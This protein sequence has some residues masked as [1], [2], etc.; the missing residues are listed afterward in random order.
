M[1]NRKS[2]FHVHI[3]AVP[4]IAFIVA[5]ATAAGYA[6]WSKSNQY[7]SDVY[8]PYELSGGRQGLVDTKD[9][10]IYTNTEIG[11]GVKYPAEFTA[12]YDPGEKTLLLAPGKSKNGLQLAIKDNPQSLSLNDWWKQS[13]GYNASFIVERISGNGAGIK[14]Y[15]SDQ[16]ILDNYVFLARDN[17]VYEFS[18][19]SLSERIAE[20][21]LGTFYFSAPK[22][23][24]VSWKTYKSEQH[25]FTLKYPEGVT[26]IVQTDASVRFI[27]N[28]GAAN[29]LPVVL[30]H[31]MEVSTV[32]QKW[33]N[34]VL[35]NY[36]LTANKAV[37]DGKTVSTA[38]G[39]SA[40]EGNTLYI[41]PKDTGTSAL[42]E[43]AGSNLGKQILSTFKFTK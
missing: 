40:Y 34:D 27:E 18:W 35:I 13:T 15:S 41:V 7:D 2:H 32:S 33:L 38:A 19:G 25:G 24:T 8:Y 12:T 42:I 1:Q 11:F 17:A 37:L 36:S 16:R 23:P 20:Q 31:S 5:I 10:K 30:I 3:R 29:A 9:W 22:D 21:M 6:I 26:V 4:A 43:I 39:R 14:I 28:G